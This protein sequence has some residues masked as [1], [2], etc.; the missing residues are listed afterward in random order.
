[1]PARRLA[2]LAMAATLAG[3]ASLVPPVAGRVGGRLSIQ[4]AALGSAAAR[5]LNAGFELIGDAD[6]YT[7]N[8]FISSFCR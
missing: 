7:S 2:L 1:M 6:A 4:V 8:N 5:G 3:C